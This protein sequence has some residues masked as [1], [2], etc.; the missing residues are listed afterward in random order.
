MQMIMHHKLQEV[1]DK[2][3]FLLLTSQ[4]EDPVEFLN[5]DSYQEIS[6]VRKN[7]Q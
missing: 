3:E 5:Q 1:E 2:L 6:M 4:S 7:L